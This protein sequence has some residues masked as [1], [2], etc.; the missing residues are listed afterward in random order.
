MH[1]AFDIDGTL[2]TDP[3]NMASLLSALHQCGHRISILTGSSNEV[4]GKQDVQDKINFL[5]KLGMDPMWDTLVVIG[6]PPHAA[7]AKWCK[8]NGVDILF[9]NSVQ[10]AKLASEHTLVMLPWNSKQD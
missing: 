2:D 3:V 6:D 4:P 1:V 10:N 7:K 9:D 5:R 8:D